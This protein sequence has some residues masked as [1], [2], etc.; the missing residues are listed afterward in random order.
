[1]NDCDSSGAESDSPK[2]EP[3]KFAVKKPLKENQST[4]FTYRGI[5]VFHDNRE[6]LS[7]SPGTPH[8]SHLRPERSP[9]TRIAVLLNARSEGF[10]ALYVNTFRKMR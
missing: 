9:G 7:T 3:A 8:T 4:R 2:G 5:L 10:R 6:N 1:L